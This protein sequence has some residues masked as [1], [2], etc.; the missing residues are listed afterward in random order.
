[1][2][3]ALVIRADARG[4]IH[5]AGRWYEQ[6]MGGLGARFMTELDRVLQRIRETP[7]QFPEVDEGVRRALLRR[8]PYGVYFLLDSAS[9]V[10]LAVLHL[11]RRPRVVR[12][13][14]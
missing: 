1:M 12:E 13:R 10:I 2:G 14:R 5:H 4:D 7:L 9:V 3:R 6:Q 11:H 8:F